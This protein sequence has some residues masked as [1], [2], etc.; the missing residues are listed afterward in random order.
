V[1]SFVQTIQRSAKRKLQFNGRGS[2]LGVVDLEAKDRL[3]REG[4]E[5]RRLARVHERRTPK[6]K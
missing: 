4:R 1:S 5:Q 6:E 2:R 3:A